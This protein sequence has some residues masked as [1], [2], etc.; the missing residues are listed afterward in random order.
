VP[1]PDVPRPQPAGFHLY[2]LSGQGYGSS[3]AAQ[4]GPSA[5]SVSLADAVRFV[6]ASVVAGG[7]LAVPAALVW[8]QVAD[9]PKAQLTKQG[10][11]LG[12]VQLNQQAEVTLWFLVV[13]FA[14]GIVAGLVVGWR[15]QRRGSV[16]VLAVVALSV[17]GTALMRYLGISVFGPDA[18]SEA[19]SAAIGSLITSNLSVGSWLAYLGWPIGGLIGACGAILLWPVTGNGPNSTP[20]SDT[21]VPHS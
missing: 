12:E 6:V 10:A 15:G 4:A 16:T 20:A 14:F 18:K 21:V 7:V 11:Y 8:G 13:G 3:P 1:D 17:V 2:G 5:P 19:A 9:P